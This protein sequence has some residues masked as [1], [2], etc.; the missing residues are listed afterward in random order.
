MAED[1][2]PFGTVGISLTTS[3]DTGLV[4]GNLAMPNVGGALEEHAGYVR[5]GMLAEEVD[6]L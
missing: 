5:G 2:S 3:L 6:L 1:K 4:S